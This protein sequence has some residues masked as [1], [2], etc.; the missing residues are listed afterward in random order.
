MEISEETIK[1]VTIFIIVFIGIVLLLILYDKV[2]GTH[3]VSAL[4]C[5]ILFWIPFGSL[6]TVLSQGCAVIPV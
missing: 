4:T 5:S 6:L 2:T 1:F 3:L